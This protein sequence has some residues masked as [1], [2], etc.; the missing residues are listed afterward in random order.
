MY[1]QGQSHVWLSSAV[2]ISGTMRIVRGQLFFFTIHVQQRTVI[3][4]RL[5]FY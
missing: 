2:L 5:S 4:P 3:M 1:V